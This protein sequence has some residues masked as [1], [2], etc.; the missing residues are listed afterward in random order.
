MKPAPSGLAL[1]VDR[2]IRSYRSVV[3][4]TWAAWRRVPHFKRWQVPELTCAALFDCMASRMIEKSD[5]VIATTM[6]AL[7]ALR[8]ARANGMK[9]FLDHPCTHVTFSDAIMREEYARHC[10]DSPLYFCLQTK[11]M[12]RRRISEYEAADIILVNSRFVARTFLQAGI[13]PEKLHVTPIMTVDS[14][15]FAPSRNFVRRPFRL[16]YVGRLELRKGIPYLLQAWSELRLP[17]AE[18][19]LVGHL[20]PELGRHLDGAPASVRYMG[21]LERTELPKIYQQ[22]SAFV[23]PSVDDGFG[24]VMLEAMSCG[25]PVIATESTGGPDIIE[26]GV[27]GVIIPPR[28]VRA[29]KDAILQLYESS[30]VCERFGVRARRKVVDH[31]TPTEYGKRLFAGLTGVH[32]S[33]ALAQS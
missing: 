24:T 1:E 19:W 7:F 8:R 17:E 16:L 28:D 31:L 18:L 14:T 21:A 10:P 27:D 11:G 22:C 3:H 26:D 12:R 13:G 9:A 5:G 30:D 23:L 6:W 15:M 2:T 4:L 33:P 29:L 32:V 20:L 25:L